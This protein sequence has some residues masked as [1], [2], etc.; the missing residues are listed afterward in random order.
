M[1]VVWHGAGLSEDRLSHF[2][3]ENGSNIISDLNLLPLPK[4]EAKWRNLFVGATR[5]S[6]L[7]LSDG[8]TT[9]GGDGMAA[10]FSVFWRF[11]EEGTTL[12]RPLIWRPALV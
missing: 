1:P 10:F 2:S 8:R 5:I 7:M 11:L 6:F 4:K 12:C 3:V 9:E